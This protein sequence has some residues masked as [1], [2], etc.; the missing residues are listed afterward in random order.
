M[1]EIAELLII[2]LRESCTDKGSSQSSCR[3][4]S[5]GLMMG[6]KNK[7]NASEASGKRER[8]VDNKARETVHNHPL[9]LWRPLQWFPT[10][11]TAPHPVGVRN[12]SCSGSQ[13]S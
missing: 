2:L 3:A 6:V 13:P 9:R 10:Y 7:A 12:H 5:G 1:D 8:K 4:L 11:H